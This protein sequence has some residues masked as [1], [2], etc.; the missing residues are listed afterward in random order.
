MWGG[1]PQ[2]NPRRQDST[3]R[4][5]KVWRGRGDARR[6]RGDAVAL[7]QDVTRKDAARHAVLRAAAALAKKLGGGLQ[8]FRKDFLEYNDTLLMTYLA[9]IT[10][11]TAET[12]AYVER[13]NTAYDKHAR[14]RGF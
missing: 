1:W 4:I 7:S 14:R 8:E 5:S 13:F 3:W 10:K 6:S 11:G 2:N 9:A 12:D